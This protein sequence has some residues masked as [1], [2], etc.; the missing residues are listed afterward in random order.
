M[1]VVLSLLFAPVAVTVVPDSEDA[2][3]DGEE[4]GDAEVEEAAPEEAEEAFST[5]EQMARQATIHRRVQGQLIEL[6][7]DA[8]AR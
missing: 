8:M 4:D 5:Y 3:E 6:Q 7:A 2:A 1:E